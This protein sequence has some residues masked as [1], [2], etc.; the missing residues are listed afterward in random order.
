MKTTRFAAGSGLPF[1]AGSCWAAPA[2]QAQFAY[3]TNNGSII[4]TGYTGSS[5]PVTIP[6]TINGLPVTA[7]E[8][9]PNFENRGITSIAF[10]ASVT[11]IQTQFAPNNSLTAFTV[12]SGNPAY[13]SAGG[14]LFDKT[15][16]TLIEYPPG[17]SG[18]YVIP[19][20]VTS[21]ANDAF[22]ACY[23]L[24][25]VTIPNNV[26]NIGTEAFGFCFSLTSVTIPASVA[27]IGPDAFLN[28]TN[29][30]A[31][32][33]DP[34][35]TFY[36][37]VG[38]VL[39][40]KSQTTLVEFP[41]GLKGSYAIPNGVTTIGIHAFFLCNGLTNVT[42]TATVT[43]L[44]DGSFA[45]CGGLTAVNLGAGVSQIATSTFNGCNQLVVIN[46]DAA[47]PVLS[48]ANGVVYNKG[49]TTLVLFPPGFS[50]NYTTPGSVTSVAPYAAED[51]NLSADSS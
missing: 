16:A 5:G 39:F 38:G 18:S 42:M 46:V 31:I 22:A 14:V 20:G 36:S 32:T 10:P 44:D 40:D 41:T 26:V 3:V 8:A 51:C 1:W 30:P 43:T 48:S 35:N 49:Q 29:L 15:Q 37:S 13:S 4:I 7:I 50:G 27:G 47:N 6:G 23:F 24:S 28:C 25:G 12:D 11:N 33:V 2:A 19:G 9:G 34:A 17:L 21:I 45:D